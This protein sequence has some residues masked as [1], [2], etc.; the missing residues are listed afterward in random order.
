MTV[1]LHS[2]GILCHQLASACHGQSASNLIFKIYFYPF[3]SYETVEEGVTDC[4]WK[5]YVPSHMAS[6]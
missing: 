4:H 1:T 5:W 6:S 3:Q 2:L